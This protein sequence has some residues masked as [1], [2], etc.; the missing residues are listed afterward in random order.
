[1]RLRAGRGGRV[2]GLGHRVRP[3]ER[4]ARHAAM[5][6]LHAAARAPPAAGLSAPDVVVGARPSPSVESA[7]PSE[8]PAPLFTPI[9]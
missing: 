6:V 8:G 1:M 3:L 9:G 5:T 7:R 2:A 4:G